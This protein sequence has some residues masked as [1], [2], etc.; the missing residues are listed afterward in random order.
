MMANIRYIGN[1]SSQSEFIVSKILKIKKFNN[2]IV[3]DLFSGT[4]AITAQLKK[5]GFRVHA[6]DYLKQCEIR[7]KVIL[8]LSNPPSFE[9]LREIKDNKKGQ[10][11][12]ID[13]NY[14]NVLSYLNQLQG[15]EGFFYKE[16]SPEG[17]HK[18]SQ[19]ERKYFTEDNAK[20]ID[21]IR[22]KIKE[23]KLEAKIT[24]IEHPLLLVSLI[25]AV[26][27]VA[28]ISGTYGCFLKKFDDNALK[29]LELKPFN[30]VPGRLD[31]IIT[32]EDTF[33][34]AHDTQS[35]V[36][37][38]DPPFTKRQYATYY[39]IPETI[40]MEDE[41]ELIGKTGIRAWKEKASD[42][43]YKRKALKA[44]EMLIKILF[45]RDIFLSYSSDGHMEKQEILQL[46]ESFGKTNIYEYKQKRF[47]SNK[48]INN[49]TSLHEYLFH[50]EGKQ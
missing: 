13:S 48:K 11:A 45:P 34:A 44:L 43:C 32:M 46:M 27:N 15:I 14:L 9:N 38:L 37:Y 3:G 1:K 2:S 49:H 20:K 30:F 41:P 31:H 29:P 10:T 21:A 47:N 16:Y 17:S 12:I 8:L 26:N 4:G 18:N 33:Q 24:D 19:W 6:N 28:N 40:A 5:K 23:W 7:S 22:E 50:L 25:E 35:E 36:I 42:F 39:H